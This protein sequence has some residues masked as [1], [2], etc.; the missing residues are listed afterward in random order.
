MAI[1]NANFK[2]LS[3]EDSNIDFMLKKFRNE[4]EREGIL[5]EQKKR[6]HFL[7]PSRIKYELKRKTDYRLTKK[8]R[9]ENQG[10]YKN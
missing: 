9:R 4:V 6:R 2:D 1:V 7:K 5:S 10:K 3:R 8:K